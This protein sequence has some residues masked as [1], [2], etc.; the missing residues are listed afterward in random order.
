MTLLALGNSIGD[1]IQDIAA[2]KAGR[3]NMALTACFGG[4]LLNTLFGTGIGFILLIAIKTA[5]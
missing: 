4:P 1:Y 3:A 2:A 5:G